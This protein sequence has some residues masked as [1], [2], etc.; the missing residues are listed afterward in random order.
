MNR[1]GDARC[2][3]GNVLVL[4]NPDG[5]PAAPFEAGDRLEIPLAVASQLRSPVRG[6]G[7]WR[8]PV[9]GTRVPEATVQE[10]GNLLSG[11]GDVHHDRAAVV[12]ANTLVDSEAHAGSVKRRAQQ[13][14]GTR[15][16]AAIR[17]HDRGCSR[18][19][20]QWVGA[21]EELSIESARGFGRLMDG[22]RRVLRLAPAQA[23]QP[24]TPSAEE[25][26]ARL[27][28]RSAARTRLSAADNASLGGSARSR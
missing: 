9:D 16:S 12:Y 27:S 22:R 20:G 6:V 28:A 26:W 11:E 10:H 25:R 7:P 23:D 4:P 15:V 5:R 17:F 13:D 1:G 19:R 3:S 14:L 8:G 21:A 2:C 24:R 18:T